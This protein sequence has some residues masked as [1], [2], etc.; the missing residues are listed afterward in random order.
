MAHQRP[1][2]AASVENTTIGS[3]I[4]ARESEYFPALT[5]PLNGVRR[6]KKAG[7]AGRT[8]PAIR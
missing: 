8:L 4:V 7:P 5:S 1:P 3:A 6:V 2:G